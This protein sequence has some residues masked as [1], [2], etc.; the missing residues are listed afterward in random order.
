MRYSPK[1]EPA[2]IAVLHKE[3]YVEGLTALRSDMGGPSRFLLD[4]DEVTIRREGPC[5]I[6][7]PLSTVSRRHARI[8]REDGLY[9]LY[10]E[11]STNGTFL[12]G[13]RLTPGRAYR[14]MDQVEIRLGPRV[15][16]LRFLDNAPTEIEPALS[17]H[18]SEREHCF[19]LAGRQ[20][21]LSEAQERLLFCLY[22]RRG[23]I[24]PWPVCTAAV[25]GRAFEEGDEARL[26]T[27]VYELKKRLRTADEQ[28]GADL[29]ERIES[30]RG[31][32]Y[33]LN[34]SRE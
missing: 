34:L 28:L 8:V 1:S 18:W 21:E 24:C 4:R 20:I 29:V 32:G 10:D 22:E 17:L 11:G 12:N 30:F 33:R 27:L 5:S 3:V 6:M 9:Y 2:Q 25:W 19:L 14:L 7:V 16:V 26:Q 15:S 23:E 13:E 31:K